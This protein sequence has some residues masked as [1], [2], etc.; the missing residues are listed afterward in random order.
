MKVEKH[1]QC[2]IVSGESGAGKTESS[3][4]IIQ[5]LLTVATSDETNLNARIEQ[6]TPVSLPAQYDL[7]VLFNEKLSYGGMIKL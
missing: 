5:H 7:L 2:C 1:A 3:K 6:V 4:Y